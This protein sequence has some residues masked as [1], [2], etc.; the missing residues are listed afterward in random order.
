NVLP[1][2]VA[3]LSATVSQ[4]SVSIDGNIVTGNLGTMVS[5]GR[6]TATL[7]VTPTAEGPITASATVVANQVDPTT[8]NNTAVVTISVGPAADLE[9]TLSDTP[10]P[11]VIQ[12]NLVYV[13][14]VTNHGPST[15][16]GV[17]INNTLATS[18]TIL[19][20]VPTQ[21]S[22]QIQTNHVTC[23]VGN[24]ASGAG[25]VVTITVKPTALGIISATSTVTATQTDPVPSNNS[26]T[27]TTQVATPFVSILA[28][29]ASLT[30]ES[31]NPANG[32][33][34]AGETVTVN[35]RLRN[36][37]NVAN[38]NLVATLLA[39]NGVAPV[40]PNTPQ[41][42]GPLQP[43]GFPIVS[44]PFS[45][46][47]NGTNAGTVTAVL[48]LQDGPNNLG[49]AS[50]TF[51]LPDVRTFA[52]TNSIDIRD[53]TNALPYPSSIAVSGVTGVVGKVTVTLS[54]MSHT[55]PQDVDVLVRGAAG[56]KTI[57]MSG[58][59]AP[60]L[61]NANVTFD[62]NAAFQVPD[63]N[64]QIL[65]AAYRPWSYLPELSLPAPAPA[66]PYPAAMSVF[67]A[68]NPNGTWSL[69][70]A[71]HTPGD[72]GSI[73]GGWSLSLMMITPVNQVADLAL[74]GSA[75]PNPVL[76]GGALTY[77]FTVT[78]GGPNNATFA[79]FTNALPAGVALLSAT[80]SQGSVLTNATS[81][82]GNL[83]SI[84][85]GATASVTVVVI[86]SAGTAGLLTNSA[87]VF[88]TETDLNTANN[89]VSVVSAVNLPL[90]NVGLTATQSLDPAIIANFLT[91]TV[92][93]T[94][95]GPGTAL[96]LVFSNALPAGFNFL[97]ATST[98]GNA[99]FAG[100]AV[101]CALGNLAS[102]GTAT[103]TVV[104]TPAVLGTF[105]NTL[106]A[107]TRSADTNLADNVVAQVVTVA[108]PSPKIVATSAA[109]LS[110]S[111]PING[112][113]DPGETVTVA[114]AL[115]NDG[116]ADANNL[117][118]TL[119]NSGGV[120][121]LAPAQKNYGTLVHGGAA[122]TN[123][124]SFVAAGT[125]GGSVIATLAL[126]GGLPPVSFSFGLPAT[127]QFS[128]TASIIIPDHG[129]ANPYP[130]TIQV[131]GMTGLVSKATVTLNGLSHSFPRDVNVLL[132]SPAGGR[133][134]LMSHAGSGQAVTNLTLS[135]DDGAPGS[136][137]S[138]GQITSGNYQPGS[139]GAS[140]TFPAPAAAKPYGAKLSAV[141]G[142]NPNGAW[143]LFVFDDSTG[144]AG[145]VANGWTLNLTAVAAINPVADL[146]ITLSSAPTTLLVGG[147]VTNTITISNLGPVPATGVVVTHPLPT[148]VLFNS[149][150]A[151][152]GSTPTSGGGVVT[153]NAGDLGS[154]ASAS[155]VIVEVP[156]LG[157]TMFNAV[158][159]GGNETDL[160]NDNNSAQTTVNVFTPV[161]P[162]L[163]AEVVS[164]LVEITIIG[165]PGSSFILD[166]SA[167]LVSWSAI[168]TNTA[169]NGTIK[170]IDPASATLPYRFYRAHRQVP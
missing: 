104:V 13:V 73:A 45:F 158:L 16:T 119:Q 166:A 146:A 106:S 102:N 150:S 78:N 143:S 112:A 120:T 50:F 55:F 19:T 77:T 81:V 105:T 124:Y 2:S 129:A 126:D 131:T 29:G 132:V 110:E 6:A 80:A 109:L 31:F 36:A 76:A 108:N 144:D 17:V 90:A 125:N 42:Y 170:F 74:S 21:G 66:G 39:T 54:N 56:A 20:V 53:N 133:A 155:A 165:D 43:G 63:G 26:A 103:I 162:K 118:A 33:I 37:G 130:A 69:F 163:T 49:F 92:V 114:L 168:S 27:A 156:T 83:G 46:T 139:F 71:D 121:P 44:R 138:G 58:A 85:S 136:L 157:G 72:V 134:L 75:A 154:G 151:S 82:I 60:P 161:P 113:I 111:G 86:P 59:G 142:K 15:A 94:N 167:D 95:R 164:N 107:L 3:L 115:R 87:S 24:L 117:N 41:T 128:N 101:S 1:P 11:V 14:A 96:D 116:T 5:G 64:G 100:G 135:F 47:A 140:V 61:A 79:A 35:L 88:A 153:W 65:S 12:S 25:V 159:I 57:L 149:A 23:N 68:A 98:I 18:A 40:P 10:D 152:Q 99:V 145:L 148:G 67:N 122:A 137:P 160:N 30:S 84:N 127:L 34:D 38:T 48:Q 97:T 32:T 52:N 7:N 4:G 147:T 51:T 28:S 93:V 91:N 169:V 22:V 8:S 70:A 123:S 89:A 62:D 9:L 141:N